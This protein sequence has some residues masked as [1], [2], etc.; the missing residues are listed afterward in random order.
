MRILRQEIKMTMIQGVIHGRTIELQEE[1]G[2]PDGQAVEV[3]IQRIEPFSAETSPD[4]IPLVESWMDRLVFDQAIHPTERIVKGTHLE[5][6]AL[7]AELNKGQTDAE[8]LQTHPELTKEDVV[9]LRN[10]AR[11]PMGLRRSCGA[12]AEDA[13]ELNQYLEWIRQHRKTSRRE[14]QD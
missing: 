10:Y 3:N 11:W 8:I 4:R 1:P 7:V 12:W 9:A 2:L 14:I 6:E 5:S 13:E